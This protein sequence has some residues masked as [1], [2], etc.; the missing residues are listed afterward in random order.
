MLGW[1]QRELAERAGVNVGTVGIVERVDSPL[2][3]V[4]REKIQQTLE[5]AGIL[6]IPET[7][8]VGDGVCFAKPRSKRD[9]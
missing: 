1:T 5:Q 6:F 9:E 7:E 3:N 4:S 2:N 8:E